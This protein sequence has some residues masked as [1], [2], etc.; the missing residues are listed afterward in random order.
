MKHGTC[1]KTCKTLTIFYIAC[2]VAIKNTHNMIS[3]C[4]YMFIP[5][6][7]ESKNIRFKEC[8]IHWQMFQ[9]SNTHTYLLHGAE[10][11]LKS[12]TVS[13]LVKNSPHFMQPLGS[14]PHLQVPATCPYPEP[15]QSTPHP[16]P[17]SLRCISLLSP[18]LC[19]GLSSG[20]FPSV[21]PTKTL[22]APLLS[23]ICTTCP[24]HSFFP[25]SSCK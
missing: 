18:L 6:S 12:L 24:T 17:T 7:W 11:F 10:S 1:T 13:E 16:P 19:L 21:F 5:V 3:N 2:T 4:Q 8:N 25:V 22:H 20:F 14:S 9:T 15:D 23:L